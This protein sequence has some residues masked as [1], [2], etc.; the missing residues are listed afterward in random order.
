MRKIFFLLP[1]LAF[2]WKGLGQQVG[3]TYSANIIYEQNLP[4]NKYIFCDIGSAY[5]KGAD[6]Y[7]YSE[8]SNNTYD[9]IKINDS[10][11]LSIYSLC[12]FYV[13]SGPGSY[14]CGNAEIKNSV[15]ASELIKNSSLFTGGCTGTISLTDFKPNVS[16]TNRTG[17]TICSGEQLDLV[18]SAGFPN[19][20]YHWQY[21]TNNQAT[22]IDV[23]TKNDNPRQDLTISQIIGANHDLYFGQTIYF[24]LGY[25]QNRP[26]TAPIPIK[27][28]PCAPVVN[29]VTY[30]GPNCSGDLI[31]K[32]EVTFDRNLKLNE[33]IFPL[34]ILDTDPAITTPFCAQ[35]KPVTSLTLDPLTNKYKY[36]FIELNRLISGHTYVVKYQANLN[37]KPMGVIQSTI[38][39]LYTEVAP[40]TFQTTQTDILCHG[41]NTGN[42]TVLNPQGGNGGYTYSKDGIN[43]QNSPTFPLL[44]AGT[45]PITVK[46]SKNCIAL[47]SVKLGTPLK[48]ISIKGETFPSLGPSVAD[49]SIV[50]NKISG[51]KPSYKIFLGSTEAPNLSQLIAGSYA[52]RIVDG[53]TCVKDTVLVVKQ[54]IS[55]IPTKTDVKC[56]GANDGSITLSILGGS[57]SYNVLWNDGAKTKDRS[58]LAAGTYSY[59]I[60]D[61]TNDPLLTYTGSE[62]IATPPSLLSVAFYSKNQPTPSNPNGGAISISVTNGYENYNYSWT[63]NNAPYTPSPNDKDIYNLEDGTYA[64]TVIDNNGLG[65]KK[66]SD[67][68]VLKTLNVIDIAQNNINCY[69][70]PTGSIKVQADGGTLDPNTNI[71]TYQY[72]WSESDNK[73]PE[74]FTELP[75]ETNPTLTGRKKGNYKVEISDSY[76]SVLSHVYTLTQPNAALKATVITTNESCFNSN[77]GTAIITATGGTPTNGNYT[78][79]WEKDNTPL[80]SITAASSNILTAGNY[81]VIISDLNHYCNTTINFTITSPTEIIIPIPNIKKV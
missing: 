73:Q 8:T 58:G 20:A 71:K 63:K 41:L 33:T 52:I 42:I 69:G 67:I 1:L 36:S 24:R 40:I 10:F 39:F 7:D 78:Y 27:Y 62:S 72:Q 48:P 15:S 57:G 60:T 61:A 30:Q 50:L 5:F 44:L 13:L 4:N 2:T 49:G 54:K 70:D 51:G 32:I 46:D 68:I 23:P 74:T 34:Y 3:P 53:N 77:D 26:F 65:C 28:L 64:L 45:Y 75:N 9:D 80:S 43:F 38:P 21:S 25:D 12:D 47:I 29:N 56:F 19:V 79:A 35:K 59:T 16:I 11:E 55:C 66:S 22:W 14:N 18:G 76:D 81:K 31:Q 6:L 17:S 37:S